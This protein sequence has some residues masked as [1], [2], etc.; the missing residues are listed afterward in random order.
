MTNEDIN[1]LQKGIETAFINAKYN[2]NLAY[3]PQFVTNDHKK[4]IKVL[5]H[6]ENELLH[7]DE[8]SI[9]VAFINRGGFV[10]LSET[11]KELEKRGIRGRILTTDY[12]CFSDPYAFERLAELKNIELKMYHVDD[13]GVGFHTKGYLFK[14]AGIYRIIVGSSNMTQTALTTNMEWNTQVV[15]TEQGAMAQS[16]V[17][18]FDKLWMDESSKNYED[19]IAAYS[20]KYRRKKQVDKLI[21]EQHRIALQ[22]EIVDYETYNLKP[23]K[24]QE[25]FIGNIQDLRERGAKRALLLSAT[26][27]GKTYASAFVIKSEQPKKILFIVHR[28]L[29]AKQALKSY[30]KVFGGTKKL[31]LLSGNSKEYDADILFAT[32]SMMAKPETLE[33]YNPENFDWI[34]IDEVHRAGSE[35]YQ[36][37]MNHFKPDFWLGMTASPERTDRFDIFDL[38]DHNIAYEIRLQQALLEDMLCPFHYFGITDIEINGEVMDDKTGLRNFSHLTSDKRVQYI[39]KQ[40]EYFGHSGEHV[41]GLVFCSG[42]REAQELS[43]KFNKRGYYTSVLTGD[44]SEKQ[45]EI[46]IDFLTKDV[47]QEEYQ[48]HEQE[49]K[50][51]VKSNVVAPTFLDYIFTIDIFN[52]GVDIPEIN[53]VLMLRPTESPI[54]FVQQLGRGLR[55]ADDKDFVVI[56][57][58]IGN[59]TNNY[60]IPIA[61]SGDRSYNKDSIRRYVSE[62]T[63]II[64][65]ASTIHFDEISRKR[66]FQSI[67]SARTN[68]VKFLK[69]SYEQLKYRLGRIPTV[70]EFKEYGSIEIGKYFEKYGSYYAFLLKYYGDEYP[71]RLNAQEENIIEFISKKVT[72]MK[73]IH[74]LALLKHLLQQEQRILTYYKKILKKQYSRDLSEELE[75]SVIRNLTNE[76]PKEEEKKKYKYCVLIEKTSEGYQIKKEFYQ[77]LVKNRV[78]SKMVEE[79]IDYGI[80]NYFENYA[81]TYKDFNL[82]LYQKYTYEDVCRLLNWNRNMNAQNIGRYFYDVETKTL[83]VFINY[84]KAKDA[85]AYED[86]FVTSDKIIA[87]SKHPRKV[88]SKDADHIFKR[89]PVDRDNRILLF[90]RKNKDDKEAKEFYFLGEIF[91]EGEAIPIHMNTTNDDAFEIS[92]KLDIPVRDDIYEYIVSEA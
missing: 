18:E 60:M 33:R 5:S 69:A 70:L 45:R 55:K 61:L 31:A 86:R 11:L 21:K 39:L 62:G 16:I 67:D 27:T 47:S 7:C 89:T 24:M 34:C 54:V 19:F 59:Y 85:I 41:K 37:I 6:I 9:S 81:E 82:Q 23:N 38:F 75:K 74:E 30:R 42:K 20:V 4:G 88:D 12:L 1:E 76:F 26:G 83:P 25:A 2:S 28:E 13:A 46:C 51:E 40:A 79:L 36:R 43:D 52:E 87:L 68:D 29:I 14:E 73:R 53:Q 17:Y 84:D 78:F 92:Y 3:R 8:F 35:S 57:D 15:S 63:R 49:I 48:K 32:M 80:S 71:V 10:V 44:D 66:L 91:A 90:V 56:I 65:G 50:D 72:N 77:M 64:P 58:F 22:E